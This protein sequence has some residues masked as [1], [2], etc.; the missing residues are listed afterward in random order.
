[1]EAMNGAV[2]DLYAVLSPEQKALA[3]QHMGA[4]NSGHRH[5]PEPARPSWLTRFT[6]GAGSH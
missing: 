2:K 6:L 3:D 4:M 1:M 5:G